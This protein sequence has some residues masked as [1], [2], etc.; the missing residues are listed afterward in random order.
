MHSPSLKK[1]LIV[2]FCNER[3]LPKSYMFSYVVFMLSYV[4]LT[5]ILCYVVLGVLSLPYN[6]SVL[7]STAFLE[8]TSGNEGLKSRDSLLVQVRTSME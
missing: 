6:L 2:L 7:M 8:R 1:I 5:K 4:F 3:S